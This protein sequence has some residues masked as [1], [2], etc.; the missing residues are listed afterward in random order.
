M[1]FV[2]QGNG[3]LIMLYELSFMHYV[4]VVDAFTKRSD[5]KN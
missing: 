2:F 4:I 5:K 1:R 3:L